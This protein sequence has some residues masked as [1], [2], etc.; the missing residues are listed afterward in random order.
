MENQL[1][2]ME[3]LFEKTENY[4]KK[5]VE[6]YKLKAVDKSADVISTIISRLVVALF[7]TLFFLVFNVGVALWISVSLGKLY[8][9]FFI[10]AGFYACV[11]LLLYIFRYKWIKEP[12]R[13]SI[14]LQA[15]K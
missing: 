2:V 11:A 3:T 1:T 9:G 14:I 15:L 10:V 4:A 7:I 6:L 8:Y 12:I 13:N 5:S